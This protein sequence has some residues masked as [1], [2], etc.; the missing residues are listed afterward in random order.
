MPATEVSA[1]VTKTEKLKSD[2]KWTIEISNTT[3][4]LAFFINPQVIE[5]GKE[6]LP[7]FW[8]D[9]YFSLAPNSSTTVTVSVPNAKVGRKVELKIS[10]WNVE[11]KIIELKTNPK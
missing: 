2:T 11:K 3:N 1:K 9:N 10:G 4:K 8:S 5:N 6:I 7:S